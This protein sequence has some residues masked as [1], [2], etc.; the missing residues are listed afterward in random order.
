MTED[1]PTP[2]SPTKTTLN[3]GRACGSSSLIHGV[4]FENGSLTF[5][6]YRRIGTHTKITIAQRFP[7]VAESGLLAAELV[8]ESSY[9]AIRTSQDQELTGDA[10][11]TL[12][13]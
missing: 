11:S 3:E 6:I 4:N 12:R 7:R 9:A 5:R 8:D 1:L 13:S 2:E 10:P